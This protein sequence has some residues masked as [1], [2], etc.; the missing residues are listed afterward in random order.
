[1]PKRKLL[2]LALGAGLAFG[3]AGTTY[4]QECQVDASQGTSGSTA[5]VSAGQCEPGKT[6]N[7][8]T[9]QGPSQQGNQPTAPRGG[10]MSAEL[11]AHQDLQDFH[12]YIQ[13]N[14]SIL[15]FSSAAQARQVLGGD[16]LD[17]ALELAQ[18][19]WQQSA[20]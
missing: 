14:W 1:M 20:Q 11:L 17:Q 8:T 13:K 5:L 15:G 7:E 6:T 12:N 16:W 10:V 3:V 19:P 4:A 18:A 2:S 9:G